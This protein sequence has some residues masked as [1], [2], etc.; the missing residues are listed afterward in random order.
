MHNILVVDDEHPIREWLVYTIRNNRDNLIVD[1]AINGF[2][3]FK[4]LADKQY[5]LVIS[6]I[7][8]PQLDGLGLFEKM[9][10][11]YPDVGIIVLSSYDDY[12]YVRSAFKFLAVDYLLKAEIDEERL[13]HSI[14]NFFQ[15]KFDKPDEKTVS[16]IICNAL[17]SDILSYDALKTKLL[18]LKI[19]LPVNNYYC[20]LIK[21]D[22]DVSS[23]GYKVFLPTI[24]AVNI[25]YCIPISDYIYI[26]C[27]EFLFQPSKLIQL[28]TQSLFKS[29]MQKFNC[30][31]LLVLSVIQ[32]MP[33]QIL[34]T[35]K[36]VYNY[37][38]TDFYEKK[39]FLTDVPSELSEIPLS[40]HYLKILD[41][42]KSKNNDCVQQEL[43][44]FF[45][46]IEQCLFPNIDM[47]KSISTK[48]CESAYLFLKENDL[49]GF[50]LYIKQ[51]SQK[52]QT[53]P[54]ISI[55]REIVFSS[56]SDL[57]EFYN[58]M[59]QGVSSRIGKALK[60]MEQ[61]YMNPISLSSVAESVYL[62]SEYFSRSFKK[63]VGINF[64]IYLNNLRLKKALILI[65][66]TD[67]KIYEISM[68][69]GF[70]NFAY[71]SK[72][73]KAM[74]GNSPLEWRSLHTKYSQQM[75]SLDIPKSIKQINDQSKSE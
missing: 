4:K 71:F 67:A 6:D 69:T 42:I 29:E 65:R 68:Q 35:M 30:V 39:Y 75:M 57:F 56:I 47:I 1:S 49:D 19:E 60:F 55:L 22:I 51:N 3:A 31:K 59:P 24:S 41:A 73:F 38:N 34:A 62:N 45:L 70:Q 44:N 72:R 11:M 50:H 37:R 16:H 2:D 40:N 36:T 5:D 20:F 15:N 63:E 66:D 46:Y 14:D 18:E 9:Q 74:Y 61:N 48:I 64:N 26:G 23:N 32:C 43:S 52:I 13:L 54:Q 21:L 7:K 27:V 10:Q 12:N 33:E 8:M 25:N 17:E 28:Q 53:T 58:Q